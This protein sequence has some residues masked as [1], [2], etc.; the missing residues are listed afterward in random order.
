MKGKGR[1]VDSYAARYDIVARFG[2]GDNAGHTLV[3][4][5]QTLALRIVPSGVLQSGPDLFIGGGTVVALDALADEIEMLAGIGVDVS[6]IKISD[7]AHVVFPYHAALDHASERARGA[8]ALGTTGRGI[9]PAY[10]DKA[11][12][13]GITFAQLR[14][15]DIVADK[16]RDNLSARAAQLADVEALPT[17]RR[18]RCRDARAPA[19]RHAAR[20]RRRRVHP[21]SAWIRA[22]GS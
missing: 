11:A 13:I 4:G 10:A 6:R 21:R 22:N 20:R 12:R 17:R 1:V 7:R 2:G 3:V 9:G 5:E 8:A 19:D 16:L 14:R 15:P 18:P